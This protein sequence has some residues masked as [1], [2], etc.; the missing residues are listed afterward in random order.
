M[1]NR[2]ALFVLFYNDIKQ[3]VDQHQ[4]NL[5]YNFTYQRNK[6]FKCQN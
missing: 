5:E 1:F 6:E 3:I 2:N 4:N